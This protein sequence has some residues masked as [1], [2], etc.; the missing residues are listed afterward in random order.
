MELSDK[1]VIKL[2]NPPFKTAEGGYSYVSYEYQFDSATIEPP[3]TD[4]IRFN[5][6]MHDQV[7]AIWVHTTSSLGKDNTNAFTQIAEGNR[8]F[9]QDKDSAA[10]WVSYTVTG[11]A[12]LKGPNYFEIPCAFFEW[13]VDS[14][15]NKQRMLFNVGTQ[16]VAG[17]P[18]PMGMTGATGPAGMT[19]AVGATGA[20]G[21]SAISLSM[22]DQFAMHVINGMLTSPM[23]QD[24]KWFAKNATAMAYKIADAMIEESQKVAVKK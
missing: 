21:V 13:G 18:G 3:G 5:N 22:R 1:L 4:V 7:N 11:P 8:L 9:I 12:F 6:T 10:A 23:A 20:A 24:D 19:G 14:L 16:L 15:I 17:P 2:P